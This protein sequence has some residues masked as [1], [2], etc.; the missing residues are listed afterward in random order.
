MRLDDADAA[1]TVRVFGGGRRGR[2]RRALVRAS[3]AADRCS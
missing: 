3:P 1:T 2:R